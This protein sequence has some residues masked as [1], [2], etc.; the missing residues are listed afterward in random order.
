MYGVVASS[1]DPRLDAECQSDG[2]CGGMSFFSYG[3]ETYV[4]RT[5]E[6]VNS[7]FEMLEILTCVY[8]ELHYSRY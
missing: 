3:N 7:M 1:D 6:S 2:G 8:I 4:Q 5:I